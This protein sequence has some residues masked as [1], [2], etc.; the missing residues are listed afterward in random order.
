MSKLSVLK[1]ENYIINVLVGCLFILLASMFIFGSGETAAGGDWIIVEKYNGKIKAYLVHGELIEEKFISNYI[2]I[3]GHI[4]VNKDS[5]LVFENSIPYG[6]DL[7][8]APSDRDRKLDLDQS[9]FRMEYSYNVEK[10]QNILVRV[11]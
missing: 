10:Y 11:E 8:V 6:K 9:G 5:L 3:N 7:V 2:T 1:K 4:K